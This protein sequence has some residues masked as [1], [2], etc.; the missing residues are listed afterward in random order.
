MHTRTNL[1]KDG[2]T[3][4]QSGAVTPVQLLL[5]LRK[6]RDAST[7]AVTCRHVRQVLGAPVLSGGV[8]HGSTRSQ[9]GAAASS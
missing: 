5:V 7:Q 9:T 8:L 4:I 3:A 6:K 2:T 1:I